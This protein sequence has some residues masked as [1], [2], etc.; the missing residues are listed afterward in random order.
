MPSTLYFAVV[1][2]FILKQILNLF[3]K[4]ELY[5]LLLYFKTQMYSLKWLY[6]KVSYLADSETWLEYAVS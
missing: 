5:L 4:H 6:F 1:S 3:K 2:I